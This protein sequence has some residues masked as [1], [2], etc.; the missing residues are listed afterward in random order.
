MPKNTNENDI[1]M[2]LKYIGLDLENIP[3]FLKDSKEIDYRP[4]KVN[5]ENT[6]KVYKYIPISN[7]EILLTPTNRLNT[8]KEKYTKA[9]RLITYLNPKEENDIFKHTTFLKMLKE[10][11]IREI[12]KIEKE[13]KE[14]LK[15]IPYKVRFEENYLWQIYYSD[16]Q[17]IYFMLVPTE[18]LEYASFFYLLKK[19][20]ELSK[21]DKEEMIFVP[22]CYENYSEQYVKNSEIS[23]LEKYIWFFT[24]EWPNIYE[25]YNKKGELSIQIV[26]KTIV[27]NNIKSDYKVKLENKEEALKFYKLLK[28]LFIL[29]TELPHYYEFIVKINQ[30]GGLDFRYE[31]K[32]ITYDNMLDIL[33]NEYLKAKD[34]IVKLEEAKTNL[35]EQKEKLKIISNK[36]GQEYLAKEKQIATYLEYKK[37]FFGRVK[38]FF[39]A[40]KMKKEVTKIEETEEVVEPEKRTETVKTQFITKDYYTI[41]DIVKIYKDLDIIKSY[42]K[43][44][45]LDTNAL[46]NKI[47]NMENKIKNATAYIEEIDKHEKSIFEFWKFAN[48][49]DSLMLNE[50]SIIEDVSKNKI[51]KVYDYVED[52]EEIGELVD[53]TQRKFTEQEKDAIYIGTT[54]LINVLN[55]LDNNDIIEKSLDTLKEE[56]NNRRI[57]FSTDKM[58][59]F[60][61]MA[62]N[63]TKIKVLG[64]KKH[65]ETAKDILKIL[66]INTDTTI[67]EYKEKLIKIL[68]TI[69]QCIENVREAISIPVYI[70][71]EKIDELNDLKVFDINLEEII[72][73]SGNKEINIYKINVKSSNKVVYFSNCIYYN[74]YNKTLPLGMDVGTKC[75]LNID[76]DKLKK[77][78]KDDFRISIQTD[79]FKVNTKK[80]NIYEYEIVE[81]NDD[82]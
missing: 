43:N 46:I 44:L 26:G 13:Q 77:V 81:E 67:E 36:K 41:D 59:I 30:Y 38:Y 60:G 5:E 21:T 78:S 76:K 40:K 2:K 15:Q 32:K 65:R 57:L 28:A 25:V 68:A 27:Y 31:Q 52:M 50:G 61:E 39:K 33:S 4:I 16:I 64:G 56:T 80:V 1:E 79:D 72:Q 37:T 74:N 9:S 23:D 42:V 19:K 63:N 34:E 12:E 14:L 75:L 45:E 48:K 22:I 70:K 66:E 47:E 82:K 11:E 53:K 35:E 29:E 54:D 10:V 7:I 71:A 18:D 6:Y 3:S 20:I 8:I 69:K 62:D 24:K 17:N 51:E 55:H 73:N 49:D 58:D